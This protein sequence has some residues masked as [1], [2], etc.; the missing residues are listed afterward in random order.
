MPPLTGSDLARVALRTPLLQAAWNYERQQGLGWAW[1]LE[2]VLRRLYADADARNHRLAEHTAYFNTQP[3]FASVCLGVVAG[4]EER[5]AAGE[6]PEDDGIARIKAV[7]GSSLAALGD[8]LFWFTL[9]P[10]A[11]ILGVLFA[12]TGSWL[13]ALALWLCYNLLHLVV[14]FAGVGWGYRYG[15]AVLGDPLRR[16]V[17]LLVRMLGILGAAMVGVVVAMLLVP[18]G[19]PRSITFQ[20]TLVGGLALGLLTAQRA[21]PSPTQWALGVGALCLIATWSR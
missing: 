21:R 3:T 16:R 18:G 20:A 15:P 2:P 10:F 9:R 6:G 17:G 8:R 11:A 5:R 19:E 4:L 7:M 12:L 1:C 13:G 14:R